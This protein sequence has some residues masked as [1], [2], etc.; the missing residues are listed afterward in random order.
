MRTN[1]FDFQLQG[2][3]WMIERDLGQGKSK[4]KGGILGDEMGLG[5]TLQTIG[6]ILSNPPS[7]RE[8]QV[9]QREKEKER[10]TKKGKLIFDGFRTIDFKR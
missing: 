4:V 5:K 3:Q 10:K 6:L 8:R 2:L 7:L 1:L 9:R